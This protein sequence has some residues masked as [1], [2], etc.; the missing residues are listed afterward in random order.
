MRADP[1]SPAAR[2]GS[3]TSISSRVPP[4]MTWIG[5]PPSGGAGRASATATGGGGRG[6]VGGDEPGG[7]GG[8]GDEEPPLAPGTTVEHALHPRF[9][10]E[11]DRAPGRLRRKRPAAH[12]PPPEHHQRPVVQ[13]QRH[14]PSQPFRHRPRGGVATTGHEHDANPGRASGVDRGP[15]AG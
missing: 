8:G 14:V 13:H 15:R 9:P 7:G 3:S 4:N 12:N 5:S 2:G 6:E 10:A 1:P 11:K